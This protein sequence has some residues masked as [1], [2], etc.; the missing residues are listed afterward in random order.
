MKTLTSVPTTIEPIIATARGRCRRLPISSVNSMGTIARMVVREV[1][2]I[3]RRRREP[4]VWIASSNGLPSF[5]RELMAS[6]FNME[7]LTTIP[8]VTIM[9]MADMMLSVWPKIHSVSNAKAVS[10]GISK[11]T[12]R[13]CVKLSN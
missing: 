13:G 6:S 5:R 1:M 7:S 11:S 9:P 3:G 12:M 8:Q 4:A 2:I 10:T